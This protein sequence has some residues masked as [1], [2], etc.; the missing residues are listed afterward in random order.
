MHGE[1]KVKFIDWSLATVQVHKTGQV[2]SRYYP[3]L[4]LVYKTGQVMSR[5]YPELSRVYKTLQNFPIQSLFKIRSELFKRGQTDRRGEVNVYF[6][7]YVSLRSRSIGMS[8]NKLPHSTPETQAFAHWT[9]SARPAIQQTV[10]GHTNAN[11]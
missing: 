1:Y 9:C 4:S 8:W 11:L 5:Y 10:E 2:M 3:E 7:L 6:F